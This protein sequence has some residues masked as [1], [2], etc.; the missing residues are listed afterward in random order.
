MREICRR[1]A[2]RA[3]THPS[4]TTSLHGAEP[5]C[6]EVIRPSLEDVY[7]SLV[8]NNEAAT[9]DA[10]SAVQDY[11]G[12]NLYWHSG[13]ASASAHLNDDDVPA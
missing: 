10:A 12:P 11:H 7:L 13:E 8:R 4:S 1:S 9:G 2:T 3:C 5:E 6:L